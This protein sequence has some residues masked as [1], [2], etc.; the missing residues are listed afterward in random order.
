MKLSPNLVSK[1]LWANIT[2]NCNSE[3]KCWWR[4]P[5]HNGAEDWRRV[6]R[7]ECAL[8]EFPG[9]TAPIPC[10]LV[11]NGHK[12]LVVLSSFY[13]SSFF[14]TVHDSCLVIVCKLVSVS[15]N[16]WFMNRLTEHS[17]MKWPRKVKRRVVLYVLTCL[18]NS[19]IQQLQY[20]TIKQYH[21][22]QYNSS[23]VWKY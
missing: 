18:N 9:A 17:K 15:L 8:A 23:I 10:W 19:T 12:L 20:N 2:F 14:I 5:N 7:G 3:R 1:T 11:L 13:I 16:Y 6:D 4:W 21:T 22:I